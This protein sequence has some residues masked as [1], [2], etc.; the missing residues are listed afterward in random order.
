MITTLIVACWILYGAFSM[1]QDKSE[2]K[3]SISGNEDIVG[4]LFFH[5]CLAPLILVGKALY[6][7]F[8]E[9]K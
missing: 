5:I 1:V 7:I 8:K 6:G 9:Y 2:W 3:S 4:K